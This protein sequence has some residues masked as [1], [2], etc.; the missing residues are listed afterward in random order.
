MSHDPV[1]VDAWGRMALGHRRDPRHQEMRRFYQE[2]RDRRVPVYTSDYVLDEVITL[3]FRCELFSEAV[4]FAEGL[5]SAAGL[6]HVIV[7]RVTSD[8][9]AAAWE[10]RKRFQDKPR[11]SF[12]DLVSMVIMQ[13][14]GIP[15][16]LTE[17]E[18][19]FQVGMGFSKVPPLSR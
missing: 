15:L 4:R 5:F 17:D 18:H 2:L 14:R 12:T 3:L 6:G 19:F 11:I 7:E 16:V 1:F 8:R 9:F 13:Q 10:L